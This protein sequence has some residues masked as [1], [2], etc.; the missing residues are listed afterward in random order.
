MDPISIA[1]TVLAI[2]GMLQ[3][4]P[5]WAGEMAEEWR[6]AR[7]GEVSPAAAARRQRLINA[8]VDPAAGGPMRQYVGNRWREHWLDADAKATQRRADR[9]D[10]EAA[11]EVL[12]RRERMQSRLD[13]E[14]TRRAEQ[15]RTRE[16]GDIVPPVSTNKGGDKPGPGTPGGGAPSPS[17]DTTPPSTLQPAARGGSANT[18]TDVGD[19]DPIPDDFDGVYS[20]TVHDDDYYTNPGRPR[21]QPTTANPGGGTSA[22]NDRDPIRVDAT[23]GAHARS[24]TQPAAT[25]AI[26]AGGTTMSNAVAQQAVTGVI[27]GAAE[28]RAIQAALARATEDYVAQLNRLRARIYSLGEQTLGTVQM[29]GKSHVVANTAAAAEAAA[30][31]TAN[32]RACTN[33]V[34]PLLGNVARA[35]DRINS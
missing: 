8:G 12:S 10:K 22:T 4:S 13:D 1:V 34:E 6:A 20:S 5:Q 18:R 27:S 25:A 29:S 11:G 15:W 35:F 16:P 2:Y 21:E 7:R 23:V 31:A 19:P 33:E 30:A 32:A 28:A 24:N 26:T 17:S 3:R 14:V 9:L